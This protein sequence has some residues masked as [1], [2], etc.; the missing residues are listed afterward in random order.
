MASGWGHKDVV[1]LLI[2]LGANVDSEDVSQRQVLMTLEL[3][4]NVD[5]L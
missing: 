3:P 4:S 5:R 1:S 2:K